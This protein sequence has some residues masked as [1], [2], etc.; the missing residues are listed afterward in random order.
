MPFGV[1]SGV[2][3]G[4]GVIDGGGY[5]RREGAVLGV[6]VGRRIVT[7]C[8]IPSPLV[9]LLP[10]SSDQGKISRG[11]AGRNQR[12]NTHH[13]YHHFTILCQGLSGWAGTR[14]NIHP[15]TPI[16]IINHPLSASSIYCDRSL[17]FLYL[18]LFSLT[19]NTSDHSHLCPLKC[20][21]IF[22][23]YRP[24]LTSMQHSTSHTIAVQSPSHYQ[25]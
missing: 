10:A 25:W 17:S 4:M 7:I 8:P 19:T 13:H 16:L 21:P 9:I 20:H 18:E 5:R 3:R 15:L 11:K 24:G 2:G 23:S 12:A 6:N 1:V 22:L 14:R